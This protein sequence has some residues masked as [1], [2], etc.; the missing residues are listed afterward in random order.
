ANGSRDKIN[1]TNV[2]PTWA[3]ADMPSVGVMSVIDIDVANLRR[4][5]NGDWNANLPTLRNSSIPTN[6]GWI[7]YVSDRRGDRDDDGE[8][9]MEDIYGPIDGILQ[10]GED[11]NLN[12]R[13]DVDT[14]WEGATYGTG[15][16]TDVAAFFD[17]QYFRRGV[18]LINGSQLPGDEFNGFT[19]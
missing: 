5:L 7:L 4:F 18:R 6:P 12:G 8:Y 9:D 10:A 13:L 11:A 19:L 2:L 16:P 3:G 15:V 14:T 17:H 1:N